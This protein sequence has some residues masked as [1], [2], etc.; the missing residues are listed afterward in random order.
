MSRQPKHP[1]D[2][3]GTLRNR[4]FRPDVRQAIS[5]AGVVVGV[6]VRDPENRSLFFGKATLER[7]VKSGNGKLMSV[8]RIPVDYETDD[9]EVLAAACLV[10][11]GSCCY[12]ETEMI[13]TGFN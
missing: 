10:L 4:I 9:L 8:A 12:G 5:D 13:D 6:D 3:P 2:Q 11:K 1:S 7:I